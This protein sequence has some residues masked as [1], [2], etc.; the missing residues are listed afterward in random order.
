[1]KKI[2]FSW[3]TLVVDFD[4]KENAKKWIS[5]QKKRVGGCFIRHEGWSCNGTFLKETC[6]DRCYSVEICYPNSKTH[7]PGW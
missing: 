5:Q 3:K 1:M 6:T 7:A 4:S 2:L